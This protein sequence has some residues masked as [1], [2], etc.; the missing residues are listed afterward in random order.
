M[1][2][3]WPALPY[4]A[5]EPDD[6]RDVP[7]EGGAWQDT[8]SGSLAILPY[9]DM[10]AADDPAAALRAFYRSAYRAGATRADWSDELDR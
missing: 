2:E 6:L 10:R 8:G 4:T 7:L 3:T 1:N 5:P 9:D